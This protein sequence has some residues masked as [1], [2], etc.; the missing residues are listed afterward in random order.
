MRLQG[1]EVKEVEYF[2]SAPWRIRKMYVIGNAHVMCL[3]VKAIEAT[4]RCFEHIGIVCDVRTARQ[5]A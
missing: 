1:E 2:R 5:E 3:G 4:I